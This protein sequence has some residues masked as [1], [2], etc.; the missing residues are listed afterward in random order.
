MVSKP[1]ILFLFPD[2]HRR[3]W[4]PYAA[5]VHKKW[6]M[7][8]M[9]LR[10]PNME[11]IM[12]NGLV[13]T[14]AVTPS[15]LCSPARACLALGVRY[16]K[17]EVPNNSCN[18]PVGRRTF[19]RA[20]QECGYSVGGVGKFD[21]RKAKDDW[22]MGGFTPDHAAYGFTHAL[23]SEGK[24]QA[25]GSTLAA[26]FPKGPYMK[27]LHDNG[28]MDI[29][30]SDMKQRGY[31]DIPTELPDEHYTDNYVG[32][33]GAY[34]LK[35]FPLGKPWFMQVNFP[36]PHT[37]FDI[38]KSMKEAWKDEEF[39]EPN[40]WPGG[41]PTQNI[42][43]IRQ[44]Y[45][46]MLENIDCNIGLLLHEIEVRGELG[47]TVI[48]YS[49]DHGEMLGDF[50]RFDKHV[51]WRGSVN[52]PLV[53]G[54]AGIKGGACDDRLVELQDLAATFAEIAGGSFGEGVDSVS[55]APL[56]KGETSPRR[57]YQ[58]TAL[59]DPYVNGGY[60][61]VFDGRYKYVEFKNGE[62]HLFDIDSDP[63]EN[64]DISDGHS[65]ICGRLASFGSRPSGNQI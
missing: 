25:I 44:N 15:P 45:A 20:L 10:M 63:W 56:L 54:G 36:G 34:M 4:L 48:A 17:C 14:N 50:G 2:Q 33:N 3:E 57:G 38:T 5:G 13:F 23:D 58:L 21:L 60:V 40:K 29:H 16:D 52:I 19:Y 31:S 55:L 6:K 35:Q 18:T 37:P 26:G 42:N 59:D 9:P 1:N 62:K 61:A 32:R 7:E 11:K 46:A 53:I 27:Y 49:S 22:G 64:N 8:K 43:G 47:G 39:E 30:I 65:D 41:A 12:E 51:P 24:Q 28:M